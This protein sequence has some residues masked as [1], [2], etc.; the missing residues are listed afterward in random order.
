MWG[1]RHGCS[2]ESHSSIVGH[3]PENMFDSIY[4]HIGDLNTAKDSKY[5]HTIPGRSVY[6]KAFY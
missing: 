3:G 2:S 4:E 5:K 6:Q 1:A